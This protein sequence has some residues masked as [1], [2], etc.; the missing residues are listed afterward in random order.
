MSNRFLQKVAEQL[1]TDAGRRIALT[2][3]L[4]SPSPTSQALVWLKDRP[5][6]LPFALLPPSAFQPEFVDRV[7]AEVR[8]GSYELHDQ[9]SYYVFDNSSLFCASVVQEIATDRVETILD[10]CAAPG[11]KGIFSWRALAPKIMIA[12]E[13]VGKRL[14]S[15]ISNYTRCGIAPSYLVKNDSSVLAQILENSVSLAIVDAP[16]SGQSLLAKGKPVPGCFHPSTVNTNANRQKRI[17]A[18]AAKCVSPGGYLAYMTCT[19][20][21]EENEKVVIW[22][23]KKFPEFVPVAVPKLAA[24]HSELVDFPAYRLWPFEELG[25]GG[26]AVLL[27]RECDG[28]AQEPDFNG[29]NIV[30]NM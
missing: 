29:M 21:I 23:R 27:K 25:A 17:L 20:S 13:V 1:F 5:S 14:G 8:P 30:R 28:S 15:L 26:F 12:N 6:E 22:L 9:G 24:H 2:E 4:A 11:G 18:N 19:Y 3:A 16:C 7:A 10:V